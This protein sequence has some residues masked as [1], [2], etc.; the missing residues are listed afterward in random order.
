MRWPSETRRG[1]GTALLQLNPCQPGR[2]TKYQ[3]HGAGSKSHPDRDPPQTGYL[4]MD[5][6]FH[7]GFSVY[8]QTTSKTQPTT[9][10]TNNHQPTNSKTN[11]KIQPAY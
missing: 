4:F 7:S 11:R 1:R 10:T 2:H 8:Q 9:N 5:V 6:V 3:V